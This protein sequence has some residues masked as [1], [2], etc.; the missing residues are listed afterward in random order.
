MPTRQP[1]GGKSGRT[2]FGEL[3]YRCSDAC[4]ASRSLTGSRK[5][6]LRAAAIGNPSPRAVIINDLFRNGGWERGRTGSDLTE[7]HD[8]TKE[9]E[10]ASEAGRERRPA[11]EAIEGRL[12][13][14]LVVAT[15]FRQQSKC[16]ASFVGVP[17]CIWKVACAPPSVNAALRTVLSFHGKKAQRIIFVLFYPP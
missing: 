8:Q 3:V 4:A 12:G 5:C 7:N 10:R 9:S 13:S 1:A 17:H 14:S 11:D 6:A 16:F 2:A 15:D